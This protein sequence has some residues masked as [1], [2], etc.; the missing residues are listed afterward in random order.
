[1]VEST[2]VVTM[3]LALLIWLLG[4]GFLY[5]QRYTAVVAVNDAAVKVAHSYG[6]P[7][8][9]IVTGYTTTE[10][11]RTRKRYRSF[12]QEDIR[13]DN[14]ERATQYI[15]YRLRKTNLR[16]TVG[17]VTAHLECVPDSI[18]RSHVE[19]T[20]VCQLKTPFGIGLEAFGMQGVR[21]YT[22]TAS[23]DCT[24]MAD[25]ISSVTFSNA[26]A[27][28]DLVSL[29]SFGDAI[30]ELINTLFDVGQKHADRNNQ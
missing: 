20:A 5:Y 12:I 13:L 22:L 30:V 18:Y 3:T 8:S 21:T 24:D 19:L 28:G 29:G 14:E 15:R 4:I 7:D 1:M 10:F 25:Y 17:E 27:S 9:D 11:L 2:F 6:N 16:K 26:L 23:A